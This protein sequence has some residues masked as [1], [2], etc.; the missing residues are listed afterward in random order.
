MASQ[1]G[2]ENII[3]MGWFKA[4]FVKEIPL[5]R[6]LW[7]SSKEQV[8]KHVCKHDPV[9]IAYKFQKAFYKVPDQKLSSKLN[10][11]GVIG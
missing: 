5:L 3:Y 8:D 7:S 9:D 4:A 11:H 2:C 6:D 10:R 1:D